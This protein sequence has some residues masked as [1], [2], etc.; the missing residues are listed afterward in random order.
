[1]AGPGSIPVQQKENN[2]P[3][4]RSHL[5]NSER[6]NNQEGGNPRKN[7]VFIVRKI[8]NKYSLNGV[9]LHM[10]MNYTLYITIDKV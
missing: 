2:L 4:C 5:Y 10:K 8:T 9:F 1:M 7:N 6:K 3:R